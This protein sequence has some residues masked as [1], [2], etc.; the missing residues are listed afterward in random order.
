MLPSQGCCH[1][2]F[3]LC[4]A[5]RLAQRRNPVEWVNAA[6]SRSTFMAF[7]LNLD[8]LARDLIRLRLAILSDYVTISESL[9]NLSFCADRAT[10]MSIAHLLL[11]ASPPSWLEIV[12]QNGEVSREYIPSKDMD[13]LFWIGSDLDRFL[14]DAYA[15]RLAS[16]QTALLKRMG[17][18]AELI[19]FHALKFS[20]A[21]PVHVAKISDSYGYDIECQGSTIDRVEV[22][23]SSSN[24][25]KRFHISRNEYEKSIYYGDE[26]RLVQIVFSN[27]A[28][29]TKKINQ[30]HIESIIEL[31]I[32]TLQKLV[33]PDTAAFRW[34]ESAVITAPDD[35]WNLGQLTLEPNF[36]IDGFH[37]RVPE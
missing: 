21:R 31:R 6:R 32:G 13:T 15:A 16:N 11:I 34:T 18:T 22:K 19:V 2:V 30:S 23:A 27:S 33:P 9:L 35:A 25:Q 14:L 37:Q 17:D 7:A 29:I 10:L 26:W 8:E 5:A 4:H 36:S 3:L 1:G 20:G 24:T 28:F 12:I